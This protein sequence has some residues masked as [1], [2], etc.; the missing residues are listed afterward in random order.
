MRRSTG[1]VPISEAGPL[2]DPY[3]KDNNALIEPAEDFTISINYIPQQLFTK[4]Q[5]YYKAH[6]HKNDYFVIMSQ[7]GIG[8]SE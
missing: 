6:K 4:Y 1:R 3:D 5:E 7:M 2:L 8:R